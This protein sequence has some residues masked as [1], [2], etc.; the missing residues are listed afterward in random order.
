M[1]V[2]QPCR[3]KDCQRIARKAGQRC[4]M[5]AAWLEEHGTEPNLRC[6]ECETQLRE[7]AEF[8]GLCLAEAGLDPSSS[9]DPAQV[10]DMQERLSAAGARLRAAHTG[11]QLSIDHVHH[12]KDVATPYA[13]G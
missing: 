13:A 12:G 4:D 8:C 5:C 2:S 6:G 10:R 9:P 7:P 11:N 1:S 3:T